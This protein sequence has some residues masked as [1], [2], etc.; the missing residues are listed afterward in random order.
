MAGGPPGGHADAENRQAFPRR[1]RRDAH[2]RLA[3]RQRQRRGRPRGVRGQG[4][5]VR[6]GEEDH[7]HVA[8][9]VLQAHAR[10]TVRARRRFVGDVGQR[11]RSRAEVRAGGAHAGGHGFAQGLARGVAR[12]ARGAR[13]TGRRGPLVHGHGGRGREVGR[14][15]AQR[16]LDSPRARLAREGARARSEETEKRS[17]QRQRVEFGRRVLATGRVTSRIRASDADVAQR[18]ARAQGG[19]GGRPLCGGLHDEQRRRQRRPGRRQKV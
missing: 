5:T 4:A 1:G 16:F 7:A 19:G 2:Q 11:R 10:R 13:R 15:D 3:Q 12:R 8:P 6:L 9:R 14:A 17:V 18:R